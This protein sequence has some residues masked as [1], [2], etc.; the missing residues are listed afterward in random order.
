MCYYWAND[1]WVFL[2]LV[3]EKTE[4]KKIKENLWAEGSGLVCASVGP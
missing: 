3:Y 1:N 4:E 2:C